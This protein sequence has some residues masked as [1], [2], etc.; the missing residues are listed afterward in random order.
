MV[1]NVIQVK[2]GIMIN[3]NAK[4]DY[5]WNPATCTSENCKYLGSIFDNSLITCD[6]IIKWEETKT[7]PKNITSGA[8]SFYLL[9]AFLL[10]T[11]ALLIA[12]SIY[13]SLIKYK[14]KQKHLLPY[15]TKND[16]L[17]NLL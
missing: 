12:F 3:V 14:T 6:V 10:F 13:F 8:K 15:Y 7:I 17:I 11:I 4:R 2:S 16:K 5:I 9:L 1:E